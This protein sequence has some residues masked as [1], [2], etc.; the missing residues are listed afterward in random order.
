MTSVTPSTAER[1]RDTNAVN[2]AARHLSERNA[3]HITARQAGGLLVWTV[4][5]QTEPGKVYT[6]TREADGWPADTCSCEDA[7]YRHMRC[8][9]MRAVDL[10]A[11]APAPAPAPTPAPVAPAAP[12]T[13]PT[14]APRRVR[15]PYRE[16]I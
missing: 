9:H 8:K 15:R 12:V 4:E 1:N 6:V 11:P 3:R 10:L 2:L 16:E 7:C 5:S 14:Q 13:T